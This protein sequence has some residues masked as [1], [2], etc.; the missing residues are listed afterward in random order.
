MPFAVFF[1]ML[2]T[3]RAM[4]S[5]PDSHVFEREIQSAR[6]N[7]KTA[8]DWA[9]DR[10]ESGLLLKASFSDCGYLI[11]SDPL[12]TLDAV[13]TAMLHFFF[14]NIPVRGGV[15]FGNFGLEETTHRWSANA[16]CTDASFF[17]SSIVRA[18]RAESCGHK[19]FRILVHES[20]ARTLM[21]QHSGI[22]VFEEDLR[23]RD[24]EWFEI[25]VPGT[26]V[27]IPSSPYPDV[28]HEVCYIGNDNI[29]E[30]LRGVD[31]IEL[32]F[33]PD[34]TSAIH[35]LESRSAL[36]RFAAMRQSSPLA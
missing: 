8:L 24:D 19:G 27:P 36:E 16:P 35:Y 33:E 2:G 5:L 26:V 3:S 12:K 18:H 10:A 23:P 21:L 25:S 15:G 1:D 11:V 4:T 17:G 14:N 31:L 30:W 13:R 6:S 32:R 29:R 34:A 28:T 7:F 20:A 9:A 22:S